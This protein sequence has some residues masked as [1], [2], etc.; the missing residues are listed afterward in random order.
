M[1][2]TPLLPKLLGLLGRALRDSDS[3]VRTA[4]AEGFG[5]VAAQLLVAYPGGCQLTGE[6]EQLDSGQAK[7]ACTQ[8]LHHGLRP[9][10]RSPLGI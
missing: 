2:A 5:G 9:A 1:L 6:T 8:M 3:A 7:T 10:L 4:A